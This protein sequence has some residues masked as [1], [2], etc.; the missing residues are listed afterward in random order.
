MSGGDSC[1]LMALPDAII[2]AP[3]N[4]NGTHSR[5]AVNKFGENATPMFAA[6]KTPTLI[7]SQ[8]NDTRGNRAVTNAPPMLPMPVMV[9]S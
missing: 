6:P 2:A 7:T 3:P 4:P 1:W 5:N 9:S 8:R